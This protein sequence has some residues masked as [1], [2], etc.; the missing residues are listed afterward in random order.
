MQAAGV[1]TGAVLVVMT[2]LMMCVPAVAGAQSI[3]SYTR[4]DLVSDQSGA[5]LLDHNLQNAWGLA[6]GPSTPAW[7][8]NNG[9]D[10]ATLYRGAVNGSAITQLPLVVSV[11]SAPTG[12]VFNGGSGFMVDGAPALFLFSTE[13]GTILGWNMS[14]GTTAKVVG[15]GRGAVFKGLALT[16]DKLYATDFKNARVD[17]WDSSF[18][19]VRKKGAFADKKLPHRFAPFGIEPVGN[20]LIVTYAKQNKDGDDDAPG[21]GLGAVD[22][23]K[24]NGK[25]VKRLVTRGPLNAPWGIAKAPKGFGAA[26]GDLLI[27]NFGGAGRINAFKPNSGH[28]VGALRGTNGKP[29]AIDGLWALKFGNGTIGTPNTLLFTAGPGGEQH[30]RFGS[31]TT[32]AG[33]AGDPAPPP[34]PGPY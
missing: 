9:T 4:T 11:Q 32:S 17:V 1:R 30:G 19:P 31:V 28:F 23:Y 2:A 18:K 3:G 8:A 20:R 24:A 12:Q 22:V 29:L 6:F 10:T 5:M 33:T 21:A 27:G 15:S 16:G 26:S 13:K 14:T 25:L 7:V 34:G